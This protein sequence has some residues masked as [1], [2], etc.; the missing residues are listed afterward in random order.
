MQDDSCLWTQQAKRWANIG[1]PGRP[2]EADMKIMWNCIAPIFFDRKKVRVILLGVTPEL[3]NLQWPLGTTIAAFDSSPTMIDKIWNPPQ[4]LDA[5]IYQADWRNLPVSNQSAEL[6]IGDGIITAAG[7]HSAAIDVLSELRRILVPG[8]KIVLRSFIRPDKFESPEQIVLDALSGGIQNFGS[9]KWRL[10]MSLVDRQESSVALC[11]VYTAFN[12]LLP[13]RTKLEQE[14]GW[15]ADILDTIDAY[16]NMP[17]N[18]YFPTMGQLE[19]LL[20]RYV[21]IENIKI[22]SYE[23]AERCPTMQLSPL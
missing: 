16:S 5:H 14:S 20:G 3:L 15:S 2:C 10:A 17:G 12:I 1:S 18:F 22:G 23:L 19:K 9:F 7:S 6:I 11:D 13:D 8:G 21:C 4:G